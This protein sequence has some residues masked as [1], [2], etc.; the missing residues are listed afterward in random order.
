MRYQIKPA[1][2]RRGPEWQRA[3]Y[4]WADENRAQLAEAAS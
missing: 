4:H 2:C 1:C 3:F